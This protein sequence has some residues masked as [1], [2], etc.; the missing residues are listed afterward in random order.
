[1]SEAYGSLAYGEDGFTTARRR[2]SVT[3][4]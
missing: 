1:V 3:R 2:F 4:G